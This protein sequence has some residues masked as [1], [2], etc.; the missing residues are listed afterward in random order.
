MWPV[1]KR[2]VSMKNKVHRKGDAHNVRDRELHDLRVK[3]NS[4]L[5]IDRR[6]VKMEGID[7]TVK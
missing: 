4:K 2:V 1:L 6:E 5:T 3:E 7:V